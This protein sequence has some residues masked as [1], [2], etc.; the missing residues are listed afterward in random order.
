[1]TDIQL[2]D[3]YKDE[4]Y[5]DE[6]FRMLAK[7]YPADVSAIG[8]TVLIDYVEAL[9]AELARLTAELAMQKSL[10][11][12][13]EQDLNELHIAL[14]QLCEYTLKNENIIRDLRE[15][16]RWIPVSERLPEYGKAVLIMTT[17]SVL[18]R[19]GRHSP[20]I[21]QWA[22]TDLLYY[23]DISYSEVTHW[24]PLPEPPESEG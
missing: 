4:L 22:T 17:T 15:R 7:T 14:S 16:T 21:P 6:D 1:M 5:L 12:A 13:R 24:M 19:I 9:E 11:A 23:H 10:V 18:P 8:V 3:Y 20:T 2:P